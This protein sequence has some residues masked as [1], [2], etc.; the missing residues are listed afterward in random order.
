MHHTGLPRLF[1]F[2]FS[3]LLR[4]SH[5][6]PMGAMIVTCVALFTNYR[7]FA[8]KGQCEHKPHI[9]VW[10]WSRPNKRAKG[11]SWSSKR[12]KNTRS[13]T[14]WM[15]TIPNTTC[16]FYVVSLTSEISANCELA[17]QHFSAVSTASS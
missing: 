1:T 12:E 10:F 6:C 13:V 14:S 11:F 8:K 3:A 17:W 15:T 5:F 2:Q 7:L 4:P 16:L 9:L